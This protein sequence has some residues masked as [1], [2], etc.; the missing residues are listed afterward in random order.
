MSLWV[1]SWEEPSQPASLSVALPMFLGKDSAGEPLVADLAKMPHMLIA[2]TTGSGKSV[3]INSI[4][5]SWLYMKRPDDLKLILVD[6]KMVEMSQFKD[7]PHL[8]SPIIT[9]TQEVRCIDFQENI[10]W[11]WPYADR[12]REIINMRG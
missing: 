2:G 7:V 10:I 12:Y 4:L 5:M 8:M 1:A 9:D 3:C 6:P 11:S